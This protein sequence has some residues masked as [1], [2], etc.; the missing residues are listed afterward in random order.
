MNLTLTF[1]VLK[2]LIV[3][4]RVHGLRILLSTLL[5]MPVKEE[6]LSRDMVWARVICPDY[7]N[8]L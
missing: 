8:V 3:E 5:R 6:W 1:A 4:V 2:D 7:V